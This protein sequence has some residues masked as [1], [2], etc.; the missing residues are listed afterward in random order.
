MKRTA[1]PPKDVRESRDPVQCEWGKWF[2][3]DRNWNR[4][5]PYDTELLARQC[6]ARYLDILD[7]SDKHDS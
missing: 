2:F 1:K 5:G 6:L 7:W 4:M 3:Y